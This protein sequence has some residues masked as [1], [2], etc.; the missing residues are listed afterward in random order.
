[1]KRD[2]REE[3]RLNGAGSGKK[4]RIR[5][6][7]RADA[8][9][10]AICAAAAALL[11]WYAAA[12]AER[13]M[14]HPRLEILAGDTVYGT[15]ELSEDREIRIGE[16][17]LCEIRNGK[18]RMTWA[19]C[20]DQIC[21]HTRAIDRSGGSIVCLPRHVVLRIIDGDTE[22]QEVDTIAE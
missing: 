22:K 4:D 7:T 2:I 21:V 8:V 17:N 19:D 5:L 14:A 18:V 16:G 9:L 6:W 10:I 11:F 15:Y 12:H 20:P 13:L 1:M 3:T